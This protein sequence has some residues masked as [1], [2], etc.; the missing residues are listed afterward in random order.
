MVRLAV[1]SSL[2]N[3]YIAQVK[4]TVFVAEDSLQT[5]FDIIKAGVSNPI[6]RLRRYVWEFLE[7]IKNRHNVAIADAVQC[8]GVPTFVHYSKLDARTWCFFDSR[9][10]QEMI[11]DAPSVAAR[12]DL[13]KHGRP[14]SLAYSG[15]LI[16]MKRVEDL[17]W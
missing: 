6:V 14:L 9:V 7:E 17:G 8:N 2:T 12:T 3:W 15:R 4:R 11:P 13:L 10:T 5:R 1:V 16:A